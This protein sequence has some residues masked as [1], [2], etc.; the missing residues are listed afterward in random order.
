[1]GLQHLHD[2]GFVTTEITD[3]L[4]DT[5]VWSD[6]QSENRPSSPTGA[7]RHPQ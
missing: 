3:Q 5:S 7:E 4:A 1:M 2:R 6:M